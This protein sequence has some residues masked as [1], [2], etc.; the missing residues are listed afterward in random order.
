MSQTF[1][2]DRITWLAYWMLSFYSY[3]I[4]IF[5]P[6]TPFLK[7]DLNLSYTVSSLHTSA[8]A[9]GILAVGFGGH[10]I[11]RRTGRMRALWI[12]AAGLSLGALVLAVGRNPI[13][14]ISASFLMGCLGSLI[15]AVIPS[16]LSERHGE[17]RAVA[18]SEA[19]TIA[20]AFAAAAPLIVG[21]LAV[22]RLGWRSSLAALVFLP[23]LLYAF[24]ARNQ[25]PARPVQPTAKT[26]KEK[27]LPV[28]YWFS[29]TAIVLV[30]S[31]EFCMIYWSADYLENSFGMTRSLA[32][33]AVSLFLIA[34]II[35]RLAASRL[36]QRFPART[37]VAASILL[38][39]AGFCA[40]WL[41]SAAWLSLVGLF[42]C[43]L[44]VAG[45][46]PLTLSLAIAAG[47]AQA[48]LAGA[49]ATLASGTAILALPLVLGRFA[50]AAG[51]HTA[52]I[53]VAGLLVAALAL[54]QL[55][56][57]LFPE[58]APKTLQSN[59]EPHR[60]TGE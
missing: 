60:P 23:V 29:W 22:T 5:G 1:T 21:G 43:G 50:D 24:N 46:Y 2:R 34:M 31:V 14:T 4:N 17:Q 44:G 11:I 20:S 49:R 15:L 51:I 7:S 19:N 45:L 33:Q 52:Y 28:S 16:T 10:L 38:A 12:G 41:A 25:A 57:K 53:L 13:V 48:D 30:V 18:I 47:G 40:Y 32:S 36:V 42:L 27:S 39:L 35:G 58:T 56:A 59:L 37:L 54:V 8:F 26:R 55:T 9:A 3:Y 6:I